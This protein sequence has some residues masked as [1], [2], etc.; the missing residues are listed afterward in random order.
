MLAQ[1]KRKIKSYNVKK[2][3]P[4]YRRF[5]VGKLVLKWK[6]VRINRKIHESRWNNRYTNVYMESIGRKLVLYLMMD[7]EFCEFSNVVFP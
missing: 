2:I 3:I 7:S 1:N 6:I 5:V 4:T